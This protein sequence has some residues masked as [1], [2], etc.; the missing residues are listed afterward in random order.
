MSHVYG[1]VSLVAFTAT[2]WLVFGPIGGTVTAA[3]MFGAVAWITA[4]DEAT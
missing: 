2:A 1:I 4:S 3:L